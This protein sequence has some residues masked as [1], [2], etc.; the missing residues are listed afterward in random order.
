MP[1][2]MRDDLAEAFETNETFKLVAARNIDTYQLPS[3]YI[4]CAGRTREGSSRRLRELIRVVLVMAPM[5]S[6]EPWENVDDY[7][8]DALE[9]I[10]GCEYPIFPELRDIT[11]AT[12]KTQDRSAKEF[13]VVVIQCIGP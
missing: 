5:D 2:E 11:T 8:T 4:A 6:D 12:I 3:V 7:I 10:Y 1:S 13:S 9:T